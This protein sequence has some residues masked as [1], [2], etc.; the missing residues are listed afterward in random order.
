MVV[1]RLVFTWDDR[2]TR[3]HF[4]RVL[5]IQRCHDEKFVCYGRQILLQ[6]A[7]VFSG[8]ASKP[9]FTRK[10]PNQHLFSVRSAQHFWTGNKTAGKKKHTILKELVGVILGGKGC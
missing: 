10:A 6:K 8:K 4:I 1:E 2:T 7:W 3:N 5:L 9:Y